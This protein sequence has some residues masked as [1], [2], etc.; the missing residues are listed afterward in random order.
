MLSA[1]VLEVV[2]GTIAEEDS[3]GEC[4]V[5]SDCVVGLSS[6]VVKSMIT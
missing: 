5:V 1:I 6:I 4:V 2:L 3:V